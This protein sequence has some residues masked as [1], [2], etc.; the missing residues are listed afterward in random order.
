MQ[1]DMMLKG[2][3]QDKF[4]RMM[5][6]IPEMQT[7]LD[8]NGYSDFSR[9]QDPPTRQGRREAPINIS[10]AFSSL[11]PSTSVAASRRGGSRYR[12]SRASRSRSPQDEKKPELGDVETL[13][14]HSRRLTEAQP[15]PKKKLRKRPDTSDDEA[16][17]RVYLRPP[18]G[19]T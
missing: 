14:A 8:T 9:F 5:F 17:V 16:E 18:A 15:R 7:Y 19:S 10:S 11:S 12:V 1:R 2:W 4:L 13:L 6:T 3:T